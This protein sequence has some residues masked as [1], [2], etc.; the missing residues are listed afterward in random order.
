MISIN[1]FTI[2][3]II[4]KGSFGI[5][6][7]AQNKKNKNTYA[8][9]RIQIYNLSHYD[10]KNIINEIKVLSC[11]NCPY[12]IRYISMFMELNDICIIT[13][14]AEKGDL[15]QLIKKIHS[16]T[17]EPSFFILEF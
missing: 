7:S 6:Y 16:I 5:V 2:K 11:H 3:K 17:K 10:T 1:D 9:K 13:E 12:I 15:S 4:G 8:I 14:Y